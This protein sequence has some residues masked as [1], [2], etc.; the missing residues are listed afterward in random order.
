MLTPTAPPP[1]PRLKALLGKF[2]SGQ[3]CVVVKN[4]DLWD[5]LRRGSDWDLYVTNLPEALQALMLTLGPPRIITRRSYVVGCFYDWGEIDLLPRLDWR[6]VELLPPARLLARAVHDPRGWSKACVAHQAFLSWIWPLLSSGEFAPKYMKLIACA[7]GFEGQELRFLLLRLFGRSLGESLFS[8]AVDDELAQSKDLVPAMRLHARR[9]AL[10]AQPLVTLTRAASFVHHETILRCFPP[11][12]TI[13]ARTPDILSGAVDWCVA[14]RA[15][16]PGLAYFDGHELK[17]WSS[18][19]LPSVDAR[20]NLP[21]D[22][23]DGGRPSLSMRLA[24]AGLQARGWLTASAVHYLGICGNWSA[25]VGQPLSV[26]ADASS[27]RQRLD[28]FVALRVTRILERN[29]SC[30]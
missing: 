5:N 16:I 6:G 8:L 2:Q 4:V 9:H 30:A 7:A 10:A 19:E 17:Q 14:N 18:G 11:I 13:L 23:A 22:G 27:L 26:G 29:T 25:L 20:A 28:S 12:P 15:V 21:N 1:V 3:P 24:L